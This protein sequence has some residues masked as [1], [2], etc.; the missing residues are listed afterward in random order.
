MLEFG[1]HAC[2]DITGFGLMGHLATMAQA[3]GVDLEI[4]WD[5]LPLLPGVLECVG[6]GIIPGGVERNRESS[7]ASVVLG[8]DTPP[9]ALDVCLDPQTSGGLLIVA[10]AKDARRLLARLHKAGISDAAVIG[11]ARGKGPGHILLESRGTRPIN[12][13]RLTK[14]TAA[15]PV[16]AAEAACCAGAEGGTSADEQS[17]CCAGGAVTEPA[18]ETGEG[19]GCCVKKERKDDGCCTQGHGGVAA[20]AGAAAGATEARQ[21]FQ[22]FLESAHA[23]GALDAHAKQAIAIALSVFTRCEPCARA[24]I[25]EARAMGFTEPEIDEAAWIAIAFGGS[26]VMMFYHGVRRP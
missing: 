17:P 2:T 3:S 18:Q 5:D 8:K 9:L 20:P 23:P 4:V 25:K 21:K 24:H 15:A 1:V 10:A 14:K 7:A 11:K 19:E 6:Q 26:P 22:E 12:Q 13:V 16:R